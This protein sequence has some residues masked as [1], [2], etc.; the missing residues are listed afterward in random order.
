MTKR[1]C[2][3]CDAEIILPSGQYF[4]LVRDVPLKAR[5]YQRATLSMRI[6]FTVDSTP[7]EL[8]EACLDKF[9]SIFERNSKLR[10]SEVPHGRD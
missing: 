10:P 8:C 9:F 1:H 5:R 2:D 6:E 3:A 7:V 4:G